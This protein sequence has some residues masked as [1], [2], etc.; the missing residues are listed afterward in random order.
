MDQDELSTKERDKME[1]IAHLIS[2]YEEEKY[3]ISLPS[4]IAAIEFRMDQMGFKQKDLVPYIGSKSR[5]S[6]VLSG[7]RPLT[8]EMI[9]A[10]HT[11]LNIPLESL[12]NDEEIMYKEGD[13]DIDWDK[14]PIK[15]M[16]EQKQAYFPNIKASYDE[17]KGKFVYYFRHM[18]DPLRNMGMNYGYLRQN[19][20]MGGKTDKYA[21]AA[22]IA[23]CYYKAD[24]EELPY[25]YDNNK[26]DLIVNQLRAISVLDEGP[27]Q[28]VN[29]L[30][31]VGIHVITLR[32]LPKTHLD[33]ATFVGKDKNPVI[34]LTLRYDRIDYFWFTLFHELGHIH[35]HLFDDS[36]ETY[37][38]DDLSIKTSDSL[39]EEADSFAADNLI[40]DDELD[41]KGLFIDC[42]PEKVKEIANQMYIHPA[43]IAGRLRHHFDNFYI[44]S[45]L[46]GN[47]EVRK[48]F[49]Y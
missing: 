28:A 48:L 31:K 36:D 2:E 22:W 25:S 35:Y 41:E 42:S 7:K 38:V 34:A 5:V 11:G 32:H 46:I 18:I 20:R 24:Q 3:P 14:F 19:V 29:F 4:P 47:G 40:S 15:A 23:A 49:E 30:N 10:L 27:L 13:E 6:D 26:F 45:N 43:I 33:G 1:L 17:I 9:K 12:M 21:L 37:F 44:L 8:L 39:E 16:Y